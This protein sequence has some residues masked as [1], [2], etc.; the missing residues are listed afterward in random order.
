MCPARRARGR[1]GEGEQTRVQQL[2]QLYILLQQHILVQN[3]PD[4]VLTEHTVLGEKVWTV[5][6]CLLSPPPFQGYS[7]MVYIPAAGP[8]SETKPRG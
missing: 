6:R 5:K 7:F 1:G 3:A 4:G 2:N 8:A